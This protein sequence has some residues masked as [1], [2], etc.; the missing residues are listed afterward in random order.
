MG[1]REPEV[2]QGWEIHKYANDG[3]NYAAERYSYIGKDEDT[4]EPMYLDYGRNGDRSEGDDDRAAEGYADDFDS[5]DGDDCDGNEDE[6]YDDDNGTEDSDNSGHDNSD[7]AD[8]DD[9][10][11]GSGISTD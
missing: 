11:G 8:D 7:E 10:D 3:S 5:R 9:G 4:K 2:V 1:E 6:H